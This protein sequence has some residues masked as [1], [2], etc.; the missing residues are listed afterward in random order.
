MYGAAQE[1]DALYT[2]HCAALSRQA[3]LL[4]GRQRLAREAVE[5][6]F[7]LAWRH[8]P[9]VARDCD[10]AGWVRAAAYEYALSPWHRLRPGHRSP[11]KPSP[12][13]PALAPARPADRAVLDAVLDLPAPYRRTL[14]LHDGVGLGLCETAAEVEATTPAA[15][16]RLAHARARLAERVP[17]LGLRHKPPARQGEILHHRL[18]EL[19]A[20]HPVIETP[21]RTVRTGSERWTRRMTR[22][23]FGLTALIAAAT[24]FTLATGPDRYIPPPYGPAAG[25]PSSTPGAH[26]QRPG[27]DAKGAGQQPPHGGTKTAADR[28]EKAR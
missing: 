20:A 22:G 25:A 1:F 12:R 7:Q 15:V 26:E 19:A 6:A 18:T 11:E 24:A 5:Y 14:L 16:G 13:A 2:R 21:A 23:A 10:P 3:F 27:T 4:T 9:E 17:D 28:E 8:W